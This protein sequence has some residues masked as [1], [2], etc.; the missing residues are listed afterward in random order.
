MIRKTYNKTTQKGERREMAKIQSDGRFGFRGIWGC[1]TQ[2]PGPDVSY[3][4][5]VSL[6]VS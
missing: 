6:V 1:G 2:G 5:A 4:Q 3:G